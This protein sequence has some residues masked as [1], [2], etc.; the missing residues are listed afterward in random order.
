MWFFAPLLEARLY[1]LSVHVALCLSL[2]S[3]SVSVYI[4][5]VGGFGLP[6]FVS[7]RRRRRRRLC[8]RRFVGL[9]LII[10]LYY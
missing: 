10:V 3:V 9:A 6:S 7:C 1:I 5:W 8:H 4:V 2:Y